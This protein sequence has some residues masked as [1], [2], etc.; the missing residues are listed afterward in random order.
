MCAIADKSGDG[1]LNPNKASFQHIY[2]EPT[3]LGYY[4]TLTPLGY[5]DYHDQFAQ[6]IDTNKPNLRLGVRRVIDI[7]CLYGSTAIAYA[8][9][10]RWTQ[11]IQPQ[12]IS[13][14]DMTGVDI[15]ENAL[16]FGLKM[17]V[18]HDQAGIFT[19]VINQDLNGALSRDFYHALDNADALLC[20]M[21]L[22]Y[23]R[24]GVFASVLRRF[25]LN[26]GKFAIYSTIPMFDDRCYS[27]KALGIEVKWSK[28]VVLRHRALTDDEAR[29]NGGV[30]DSFVRVYLV[31]F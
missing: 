25:A 1:E 16:Q 24:D 3:P 5:G 2:S 8:Q 31:E 4:K 12:A 11:S 29:M 23:V 28:S 6:L 10:A 13:H 17:D 26:G 21:C 30:A 14:L 19:K 15:S 18:D 7:G 27:P 9:G 22:S 20:M